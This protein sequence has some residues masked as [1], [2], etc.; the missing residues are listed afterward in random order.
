MSATKYQVLAR[1]YNRVTN[2]P[3]TNDPKNKYVKEIGF[4]TTEEPEK[5]SEKTVEGSDPSNV[6]NNML[7]SYMGT[8]MINPGMANNK[9]ELK[10]F[11]GKYTYV[12]MEST[13]ACFSEGSKTPYV[14]AD[15][16]ERV[17]FD[18]WF[19][20]AVTGSL[21]AALEKA[22]TV[23]QAIGIKNV[24]IIKLVNYDQFIKIK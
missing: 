14:I 9:E 22:K 20:V 1:Y 7:F 23:I 4:Y 16:Y 8:Y 17:M 5:I 2:S 19:S 13:L 3:I 21:Q 6:K 18:P 24:K 15:Q 10:K 12:N 11:G